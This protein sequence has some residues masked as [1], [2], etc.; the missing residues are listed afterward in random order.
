[1]SLYGLTNSGD[2][3][4][5]TLDEDIKL[6]LKKKKFES[7]PSLYLMGTPK[8]LKGILERYVDDFPNGGTEEFQRKTEKM[9]QNF[10][11]RPHEWN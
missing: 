8:D 5:V 3:W 9:L 11:S 4:Y 10:D 1:M 6:D 7:D 2:Y